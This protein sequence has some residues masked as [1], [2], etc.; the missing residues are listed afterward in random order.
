MILLILIIWMYLKT[1]C[2]ETKAASP[3]TD[4]MQK[5]DLFSNRP[6]NVYVPV[7]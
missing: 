4:Y 7:K 3:V 6:A 1:I 2:S 5:R